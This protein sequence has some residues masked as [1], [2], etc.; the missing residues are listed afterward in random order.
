MIKNV[1]ILLIF[2][3]N[4]IGIYAQNSAYNKKI[5][6]DFGTFKLENQ[7]N[8]IS[9]SAFITVDEEKDI[10]YRKGQITNK[11]RNE[12]SVNKI[13][14]HYEI[15]LVSKSIYNGDTTNTWLFGTQIFVNGESL[16]KKEFP[17]GFV[18][19]VQTEPTL[20]HTY[21]SNNPNVDIKIKWDRAIYEPRVP[22]KR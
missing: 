4:F 1:I 5:Y 14:Y 16:L 20:I 3:F 11:M 22:K 9:F 18:V 15:Y 13:E 21:H 19:S 7:G 12:K 2:M 6:R 17:D 8:V 10:L